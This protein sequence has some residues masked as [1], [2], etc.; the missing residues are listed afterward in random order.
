MEDREIIRRI[1]EN[2][3]SG[4]EALIKKYGRLMEYVIDGVLQNR[5]N[6][7][8][9]RNEVLIAVWQKAESYDPNKGSL[10]SWL[11]A[12]SRNAARNM[13]KAQNRR[14]M[15]EKEQDGSEQAEG[16]PESEL[17]RN[18]ARERLMEAIRRLD[19]L[20]S[21][22]FYRK[23]YYMQSTSQMAAELGLTERAAEGRLYRLRK[24][25]QKELGGDVL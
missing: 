11:T 23:Y 24:R 16:T 7:E 15:N 25:L 17:L 21:A 14:D 12:I 4:M 22:L 5:N 20:E 2:D 18:E 8:D 13:L 3:E 6:T 10:A 1:K 19:P 9:C